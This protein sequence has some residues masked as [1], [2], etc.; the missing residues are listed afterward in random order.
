MWGPQP[1]ITDGR[2]VLRPFRPL[3]AWAMRAWDQDPE[4]QRYFD[5][6]PLPPPDEHLRRIWWVIGRWAREYGSGRTIPFVIEDA[7]RGEVLGSVELHDVR[8][9]EAEISFMTVPEHRRKGV[10]S[11]AVTLLAARAFRLFGIR[12]IFLDH[13]PANT[14]SE[15]VA[16]HAG[17]AETDRSPERVR[18]VLRTPGA[19]P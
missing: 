9:D 14:A 5:Y 6:P 4:T 13:D 2:L 15:A 16:R 8:D 17:F 19:E 11:A 1:T 10:A 7:E 3:D 18:T 12:R